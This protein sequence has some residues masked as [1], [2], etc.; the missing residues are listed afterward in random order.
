LSSPVW[1]PF[2]RLAPELAVSPM[3]PLVASAVFESASVV[4]KRRSA[5]MD[6]ATAMALAVA[7][8]AIADAGGNLSPQSPRTGIYWGTGM[9]AARTLEDGYRSV[10]QDNNWRMRPTSVVTAMNNAPAAVIS[11]EFGT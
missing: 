5:P 10:F 7:R 2:V 1:A 6:R 9:G 3:V 11:L 4:P 8:Q